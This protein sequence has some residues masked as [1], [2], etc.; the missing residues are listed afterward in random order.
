MKV[1][2]LSAPISAAFDAVSMLRGKPQQGLVA[3]QHWKLK[4]GFKDHHKICGFFIAF[5]L[6]NFNFSVML[7]GAILLA[8]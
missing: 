7:F 8:M 1:N 4:G 2:L 5:S 6:P 3:W